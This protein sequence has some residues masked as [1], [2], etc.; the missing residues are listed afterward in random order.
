MD[1]NTLILGQKGIGRWKSWFMQ[2]FLQGHFLNES[3]NRQWSGSQD[4]RSSSIL[5]EED[6]MR[7]FLS[8]LS[9]A[10]P[11]H[12]VLSVGSK[13]GIQAWLE[14]AWDTGTAWPFLLI[15]KYATSHNCEPHCPW[16]GCHQRILGQLTA[17]H[18][19]NGYPLMTLDA[20]TLCSVSWQ[21]C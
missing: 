9:S 21:S 18:L 11:H 12:S 16:K 2:A 19:V 8:F 20:A 3:L 4:M 6:F 17:I 13:G 7:Y 10:S 14:R 1:I 15:T 5:A